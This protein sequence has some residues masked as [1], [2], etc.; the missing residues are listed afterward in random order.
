MK[1][2]VLAVVTFMSLSSVA[3]E[4]TKNQDPKHDV[5][6]T[7]SRLPK[8]HI[9]HV[10]FWHIRHELNGTGTSVTNDGVPFDLESLAAYNY[11]IHSMRS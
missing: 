3:M 6:P 1:K 8:Q 7:S 5:K 4:E 11:S 9:R 2:Y 10:P